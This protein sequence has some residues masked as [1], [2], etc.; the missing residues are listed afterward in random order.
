MD[1][2]PTL[3][4]T[5]S[6]IETDYKNDVNT[7]HMDG[8]KTCSFNFKKHTNDIII[9]CNSFF[10]NMSEMTC[11]IDKKKLIMAGVDKNTILD[12]EETISPSNNTTMKD[13]VL[14][15]IDLETPVEWY[16]CLTRGQVFLSS[17][18]FINNEERNMN[19]SKKFIVVCVIIVIIALAAFVFI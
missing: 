5:T 9:K 6:S 3:Y 12:G 11:K 8:I 14:Y 10:F 16:I 4:E 17:R 13:G 15:R 7:T 1:A 18:L 2:Q 19:T